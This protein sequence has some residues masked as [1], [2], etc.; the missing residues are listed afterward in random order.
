[1]SF[2]YFIVFK[3]VV[4]ISIARVS[5]IVLTS[6]KDDVKSVFPNLFWIM[7]D[8]N[9]FLTFSLLYSIIINHFLNYIGDI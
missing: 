8:L 2:S 1:M 9:F 3:L 4:C 6:D 7:F 5:A